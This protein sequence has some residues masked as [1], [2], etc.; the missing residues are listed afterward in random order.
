MKKKPARPNKLTRETM[1]RT[2][3]GEGIVESRSARAMFKK[4]GLEDR[5][6]REAV[7]KVREEIKKHGTIS[8]A[9]YKKRR[10]RASR[11]DA[12]DVR[13]ARRAL[14][15]VKKHGTVTQDELDRLRAGREGKRSS[16]PRG[17][18]QRGN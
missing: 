4:L 12:L 10:T 14:A 17:A 2:D 1:A 16:R 3:R 9:D 6:D 5:A 7:R 11:V 18:R 8:W 13:Q 15:D